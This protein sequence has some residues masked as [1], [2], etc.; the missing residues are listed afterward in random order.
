LL[1]DER[2]AGELVARA[3]HETAQEHNLFDRLNVLR[4]Q[5]LLAMR[6]RDF[7][8]AQDRLQEALT[9]SAAMPFPYAEAK[10]LYTTG[11]LA[12]E[13]GLPEQ[14]LRQ[15]LAARAICEQLGERL[16]A[17]YI[18]QA[19]AGIDRAPAAT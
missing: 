7:G 1:G 8:A 14:A 10:L 15:L 9:L 2:Q 6:Q 17:G 11:L 3:D 4:V 16:Y 19:L 13:S 18:E 12:L 5:A